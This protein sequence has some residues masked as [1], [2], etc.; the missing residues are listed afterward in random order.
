[1]NYSDIL[2]LP[3]AVSRRHAPMARQER[4]KQFMPFAALKGY[5]DTIRETQDY[6]AARLERIDE[7][8]GL[9]AP[10]GKLII[11]N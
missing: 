7:Q 5:D 3:R 6:H 11:K 10:T 2:S 1:M 9:M 8:R 4:A